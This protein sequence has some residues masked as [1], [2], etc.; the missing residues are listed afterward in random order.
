[1]AIWQGEEDRMVPFAHGKW[2]AEHVSGAKA[3]LL[4]GEGHISLEVGSYG[5]VL[6]EL[7][8]SA[9]A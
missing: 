5:E 7:I 8:A 9:A 3:H 1:M 4:P 6:D 2:L